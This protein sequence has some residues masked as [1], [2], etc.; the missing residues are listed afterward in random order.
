MISCISTSM[1]NALSQPCACESTILAFSTEMFS[2]NFLLLSS[3]F[4]E[5]WRKTTKMS[6]IRSI[7]VEECV[8]FLRPDLLE[9]YRDMIPVSMMEEMLEIFG[10]HPKAEINKSSWGQQRWY[11]HKT[12]PSLDFYLLEREAAASG[13]EQ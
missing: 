10:A 5:I 2:T 12:Q 11:Y 9:Q 8:C 1:E 3:L 13:S 4:H 6:P 7:L